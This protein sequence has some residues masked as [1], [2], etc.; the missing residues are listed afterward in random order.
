MDGTSGSA[1]TRAV[2]GEEY[3]ALLER[4]RNLLERGVVASELLDAIVPAVAIA[5]ER[6]RRSRRRAL[7]AQGIAEAKARGV[8]FGSEKIQTPANFRD[9]LEMQLQ[10]KITVKQAARICGCSIKTFYR[11]KREFVAEKQD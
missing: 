7:Q 5:L 8:R 2:L 1:Q 3:P 9:I 6:E 4:L 10:R 11:M